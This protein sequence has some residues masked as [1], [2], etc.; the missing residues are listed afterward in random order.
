MLRSP[1]VALVALIACAESTEVE[2]T[3]E[4]Y[5]V[6][7]GDA[8]CSRHL[9]CA[10]WTNGHPCHPGR[11]PGE[12]SS[13]P[14][15]DFHPER[16][17]RCLAWLE[18]PGCEL[19]TEESS[20]SCRRAI[21]G[22]QARGEACTSSDD[23]QW[24]LRCDPHSHPS[25]PEGI[26][27]GRCGSRLGEGEVCDNLARPCERDLWCSR[28]EDGG[29]PTCERPPVE[30]ERCYDGGCGFG[31]LCDSAMDV[32]YPAT[33]RDGRPC[34]PAAPTSSCPSGYECASEGMC[35]P[36]DQPSGPGEACTSFECVRN[37]I[38]IDDVCTPLAQLGEPCD[39][40]LRCYQGACIEGYCRPLPDGE[41]C[42]RSMDCDGYCRAEDR[43]CARPV[44]DGEPCASEAE[45]GVYPSLCLDGLCT[46]IIA[47]EP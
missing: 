24:D 36:T 31:L 26:C 19:W 21:H 8:L 7:L 3:E 33:E 46:E 22:S 38:C 47:C 30:G 14:G 6:R 18:G 16:A 15:L 45:C 43:V 44:A 35:Q 2:L 29:P 25:R 23:C 1:V 13:H 32:C 40:A 28:P 9:R 10:L 42:A 37:F 4:Q 41:P 5:L 12:T 34:D 20:E 17:Q 27:L 11:I 39:P